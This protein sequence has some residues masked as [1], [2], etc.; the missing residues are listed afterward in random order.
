[1]NKAKSLGLGVTFH[2][3]IDVTQEPLKELQKLIDLGFDRVLTSGAEPTVGEG[4]N[5]LQQMV[6]LA[7]GRIEIMAGCGI[8]ETNIKDYLKIGLDAVHFQA[9]VEVKSPDHKIFMG[10]RTITDKRKIDKIAAIINSN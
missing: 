8:D 5:C 6:Q 2:R 10:N 3:A 7:N 9:R 4:I 1:M